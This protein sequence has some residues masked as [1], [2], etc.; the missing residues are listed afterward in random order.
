MDAHNVAA[1]HVF[2]ES[3]TKR[4][5]QEMKK[6]Y[7]EELFMRNVRY[8]AQ[9]DTF[10]FGSFI[11]GWPGETL[12]ERRE[13]QALVAEPFFD[14]CFINS[15]VYLANSP[16]GST[17][18]PFGILP[19]TPEYFEYL[20]NGTLDRPLTHYSA[21]DAQAMEQDEWRIIE[22]KIKNIP[23]RKLERMKLEGFVFTPPDF[24]VP[25]DA[26]PNPSTVE[27]V[28]VAAEPPRLPGILKLLARDFAQRKGY[29]LGP[30]ADPTTAQRLALQLRMEDTGSA[31]EAVIC[32]AGE[33]GPGRRT[34]LF[35]L[36]F[37]GDGFDDTQAAIEKRLLRELS[38]WEN[39]VIAQKRRK[40]APA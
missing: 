25:D 5:R 26:E 32:L 18:E 37:Q 2:P 28:V 35:Q 29:R 21:A 12:L 19:D 14:A 30:A 20:E 34:K 31:I 38:L 27:A 9:K 11:V 39:A 3:G 13:T 10:L 6:D 1:F 17:L 4:I 33:D 40:P 8:F 36:I 24:S 16:I 15:L 7:D 23:A 22:N